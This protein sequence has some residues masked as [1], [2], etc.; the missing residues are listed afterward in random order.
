MAIVISIWLEFSSW[1]E[2]QNSKKM[3]EVGQQA[4]LAGNDIQVVTGNSN[5]G[6]FISRLNW[7]IYRHCSVDQR[8]GPN[9]NFE[10]L[11][12]ACYIR[13]RQL[14]CVNI[15]KSTSSSVW[16]LMSKLVFQSQPHSIALSRSTWS[17]SEFA[18]LS[19]LSGWYFTWPSRAFSQSTFVRGALTRQGIAITPLT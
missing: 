4:L 5:T 19:S 13:H 16:I 17:T 15:S 2:S 14:C 12:P 3:Q 18:I 11:P 8:L 7:S 1:S 9:Q 6:S 10:L